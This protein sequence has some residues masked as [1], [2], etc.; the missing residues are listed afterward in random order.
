VG[1]LLIAALGAF[2]QLQD[3]FDTIWE[4]TPSPRPNL[5]RLLRTRL[6]SF[7]MVLVV[8][9][10]LLVSLILNAILT[11]VSSALE[12]RLPNFALL[13]TSINVVLP[14][15]VATLLFAVMFKVLPDVY[16]SWRDV[17]PGA[18]L[19][20]VLFVVGKS[21]I[22]FYLG[23]SRLGTTYGA[24][25]SVL[26][27]LVWVYYTAQIL[28]FGAEFTQVYVRRYRK[29]RPQPLP[30][31]VHVTEAARAREGIPHL[32]PP[33]EGKAL[34]S[35]ARPWLAPAT[36]SGP[37]PAAR[38]FTGTLVGFVAGLG[39]G[40]LVAMRTLRGPS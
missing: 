33:A 7:A 8:G 13:A 21:L 12:S 17:W 5:L 10:L 24:A 37:A 29:K 30:D 28:F 2:S 35:R 1:S 32:T 34:E 14:L 39:A 22:G 9:F 20:G 19:T 36:R 26:I 6:I 31:A 27:I 4:V 3:A 18:L 15:V 23:T 11:S 38:D 40:I 16:L 25:G